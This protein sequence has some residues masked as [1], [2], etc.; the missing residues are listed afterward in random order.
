MLSR[1]NKGE[2]RWYNSKP[3]SATNFLA[4]YRK[5]HYKSCYVLVAE[6][7]SKTVLQYQQAV[8]ETSSF[9]NRLVARLLAL[10]FR[11]FRRLLHCGAAEEVRFV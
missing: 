11:F 6:G 8:V 7:A 1:A 9:L 5:V 4:P 2:L 3:Y 10:K